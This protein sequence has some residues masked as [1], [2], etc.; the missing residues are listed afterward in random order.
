MP[1]PDAH[2]YFIV[3]HGLDA[4]EAL[5]NFIWRTG[6]DAS[7]I[8]HR[9]SQVKVGDR[10]IGFAYTTSDRRE[11]PLSRVTGFFECVR[12]AEYRD[13]PP[14]K[15]SGAGGD[16]Q[17]W[18]IEGTPFGS[19]PMEPVGVPPIEGLLGKRIW[20]NQAVV[21]ITAEDFDRIRQYTLDHEFDT[22]KIPLLRREPENEQEL[23]AIVV[24]S[25]QSLGIENIHR[26]RK[27]FPD[28]LVKI[29]GSP[30]EVHLELEVYSSGFF[31]HGHHEHVSNGQFDGDQK[32]VAV[33][34]WI[35]DKK[36]VKK[37]VHRV[38]ELQSLIREDKR[39]KW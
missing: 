9:F 22:K 16:E 11:R 24:S 8:P 6:V 15:V 25:Y 20:K 28:L 37:Y 10:W 21:P 36:D 2:N 23:L 30:E 29:E 38:Y 3:K 32:P 19:Q 12:E 26:V 17:A 33:L 34:C 31:A 35:D 14:M 4:F 1:S 7:T 5:P 27:A 13:I 39:M 18:L